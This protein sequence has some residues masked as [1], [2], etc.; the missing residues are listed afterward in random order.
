MGENEYK[1]LSRAYLQCSIFLPLKNRY[2]RQIFHLYLF[3]NSSFVEREKNLTVHLKV[4]T[5]KPTRNDGC[6]NLIHLECTRL[7]DSANL[8]KFVREQQL[9]EFF[10]ACQCQLSQHPRKS[11]TVSPPAVPCVLPPLSFNFLTLV[12]L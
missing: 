7:G 5:N 2:G 10:K 9:K 12:L 8:S 3:S 6:Y 4:Y 11:E 1:L